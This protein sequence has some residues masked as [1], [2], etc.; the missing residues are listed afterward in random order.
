MI[1]GHG[2]KNNV[3]QQAGSGC[4]DSRELVAGVLDMEH[5]GQESALMNNADSPVVEKRCGS[6]VGS[7]NRTDVVVS[8]CSLGVW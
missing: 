8:Q 3:E 2:N 4:K 7:A 1:P 5:E 6:M